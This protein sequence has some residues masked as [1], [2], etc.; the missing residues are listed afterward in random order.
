MLKRKWYWVL[1]AFIV[2]CLSS[3]I[4][5]RPKP[6]LEPLKIYKAVAPAP[7]PSPTETDMEETE[8]ATQH[9]HGHSHD[10]TD[11]AVSHSYTVENNTGGDRY[12]WQDDNAFD[13]T[14]SESDPWKQIYPEG[15]STDNTDDTYPPRDWYKTEDPVL[16]IEYLQ[17]QL[18]KQFGD[19]P[20]VHTVVAFEERRKL[21]IP[22][23]DA[24]EYLSFLRAQYSLWPEEVTL[25]T[26]KTLEK[27]IAEGV[28]IVFGPMEAP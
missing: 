4:L 24:D 27:Q 18:I 17:A 6:Q 25:T 10:H 7:K 9:E 5:F 20:E 2:L 16:Y 3:F 28:D 12:D 21:G 23:K 11:G 22:I 19:I 13:S 8:I 15:E 1:P 14:V 26:L